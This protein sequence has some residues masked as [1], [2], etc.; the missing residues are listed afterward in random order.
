MIHDK[1]WTIEIVIDEDDEARRTRAE[2]HLRTSD[3]TDLRGVGEARRNPADRDVPEIGDE[4][5]VARALA[6]L[7]HRLLDVA[8]GD[9]EGVT[10]RPAHL[11]A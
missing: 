10:H 5:A 2:A 9:I 8:V 6:D 11:S 4:L 3:Q 7:G 1:R